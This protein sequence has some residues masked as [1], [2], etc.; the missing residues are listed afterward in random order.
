MPFIVTFARVVG[1]PAHNNGC[2]PLPKK[3]G[4]PCFEILRYELT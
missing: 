3:C 1:E 2:G 4:D